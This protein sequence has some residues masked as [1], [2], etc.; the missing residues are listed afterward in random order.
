MHKSLARAL[1]ALA[2]GALTATVP[3][4]VP[5]PASAAARPPTI[6]VFITK[7]HV[8]R[9]THHMRPGVHRFVIHSAGTSS[10]QIARVHP[11]YTDGELGHDV[12]TGVNGGDLTAFKRFERNVTLLGGIE[13]RRGEH[14]V[15]Y[16]DLPRGHRYI[17]VDT[18][19]AAPF[20]H[21][22][23]GGHR[24]AGRMPAGPTVR[25]VGEIRWAGRPASI[26]RSGILRFANRS[27]DN[28]F[29]ALA[30]LKPGKT[31][32]DWNAFIAKIK[33]GDDSAMPPTV[34]NSG[35]DTGVVSPGHVFSFRYHL[36]PGHYVLTC[37]W[38][39]ADMG[40]MPHARM[41]MKRE[42]TVR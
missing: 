33:N 10:F 27:A 21:L 16:V 22:S 30:R 37:W 28:H 29:V 4:M 7:G 42:L 35:L 26:P 3:A 1:A 34:E 24:V 12:A 36:R 19:G 40:G 20:H 8:V 14:G 13:T 31:M 5:A 38:G 41:G 18:N 2:A 23:V 39:D 15:M 6:K 25:A 17:T 11:G 9:M 32:A